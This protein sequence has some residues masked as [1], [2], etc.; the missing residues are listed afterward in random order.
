MVHPDNDGQSIKTFTK[1]LKSNGWIVSS[2]DVSYPD[3]GNPFAGSCQLILG[4][5]L[6]CPANVEP[7]LLKHPPAI[8]SCSLAGFIWEPFNWPEHSISLARDDPS[9]ATQDGPTMTITLSKS[10]THSPSSVHLKYHIHC[11]GSDNSILVGSD[12]ISVDGLCPACNACPNLNIFQTYFGVKFHY[13]A[14]S[15][16]CAISPFKFVRCF[17]FIDQLTYRLSQ[18]PYKLSIDAVMPAHTSAW[19]FKQVHAHLVYLRDSNCKIFSPNQFAAPAATI[20]AFI[21]GAIGVWLPLHEKWV[22]AYSDDS[23]MSIIRD[24]ILNPSKIN[25]ATL[26]T[27]NYNFRAPL[28][29]SLI[30]IENEM[31]FYKEPIC[32]GSSYTR[33]QLIPREFYNILFIAFHS[34]P[35]DGHMNTYHTLHR[36]HPRY[37]WPGMYSYIKRMC[38]VCPGRALANPTKSKSSKLVHNFPIEAPFLVLFIDV[39]SV[40]KHS[41]FDGLEVYLIACCR[42]T[43]FASMEPIQHANSKT[44]ASGIMKVQLHYGFYHSVVLDKDRNFLG[45]AVKRL[46]SF[47][48][49]AMYSQATTITQ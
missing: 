37:Y 14:H 20:E 16:I 49:I 17:G 29:Q 47:K 2:S 34:N 6:S 28:H 9:F 19:L 44:F 5:H 22:Q 23:E 15:Y 45:S 8:L 32:S 40:R 27:V 38:T 4:I 36:L 13:N 30:F 42:M 11:A 41:S 21:N 39:Y 26:N 10:A 18:P 12:V 3:L 46:T 7:L 1:N 43:G 48:S 24:L 35:V 25:T 31:L 33:L